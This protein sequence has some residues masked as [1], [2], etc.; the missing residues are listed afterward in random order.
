[1]AKRYYT[2]VV[3]YLDCGGYST[4]YEAVWVTD[5]PLQELVESRESF[6]YL[7]ARWGGGEVREGTYQEGRLYQKSVKVGSELIRHEKDILFKQIRNRL[8]IIRRQ[9]KEKKE[10][11]GKIM[12]YRKK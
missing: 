7:Q 5:K 2:N 10:L 4:P 9:L 1:M 12:G 11:A 6:K 3:T 8:E